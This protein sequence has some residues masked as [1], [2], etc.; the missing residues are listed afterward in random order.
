MLRTHG[1]VYVQNLCGFPQ[2]VYVLKCKLDNLCNNF[3]LL[4]VFNFSHV[5]VIFFTKFCNLRS[6]LEKK[7]INILKV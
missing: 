4:F 5:C 7:S 2:K 6:Q 3:V 1:P